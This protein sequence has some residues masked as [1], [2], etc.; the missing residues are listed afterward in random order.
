[1][2]MLG[3][4]LLDATQERESTNE[5]DNYRIKEEANADAFFLILRIINHGKV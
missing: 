4:F 3:L 2:T 5:N 1:M